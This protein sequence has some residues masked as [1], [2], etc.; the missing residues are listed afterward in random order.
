MV[1]TPHEQ[2]TYGQADAEYL[3]KGW[4]VMAAE[5]SRQAEEARNMGDHAMAEIYETQ[6]DRYLQEAEKCEGRIRW[7]RGHASMYERN[8]A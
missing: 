1:M 5:R 6:A 7:Y 3:K 8:E 4:L 2:Y